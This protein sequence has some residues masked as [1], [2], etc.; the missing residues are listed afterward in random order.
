MVKKI[1]AM[2]LLFFL[3]NFIMLWFPAETLPAF[4]VLI[5]EIDPCEPVRETELPQ[6][7]PETEN[8]PTEVKPAEIV[9]IESIA[10]EIV[11]DEIIEDPALVAVEERK[12]MV[13]LTFDDGPSRYTDRI[14]DLLEEH[15]GQAT[16]FVLGYRVENHRD[17]VQRAWELGSEIASHSWSHARL[18]QLSPEAIVQDLQST[19]DAIRSVTGYSPPIMRPPFGQT[20]ELVRNV[21]EELGYAIVNWNIDTLDW[22]YRDADK[23]YNTIMNEVEDGSFI[24]LHDI[25]TTTAAAME[26]VIPSL[27]SKGYQLVTVSELLAYFYGELEPGRIYGRQFDIDK[28]EPIEIG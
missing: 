18:A 1:F 13:S 24:V 11:I 19:S 9:T 23:I 20:S 27:I 15:G 10:E 17:T 14:L 2:S 25:H 21:T 6:E 8:A 7:K 16:F 5:V 26:K 22:R 4:P 3:I 28:E 12:P